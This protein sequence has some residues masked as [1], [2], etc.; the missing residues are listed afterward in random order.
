ML[1]ADPLY[2]SNIRV[3][4]DEQFFEPPPET[5]APTVVPIVV[6]PVQLNGV[7]IEFSGSSDAIYSATDLFLV[8]DKHADIDATTLGLFGSSDFSIEFTFS[9]PGGDITPD[10][11][12]GILLTC[13]AG[14]GCLVETVKSLRLQALL[15]SYMTPVPSSSG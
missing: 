11:D 8:D 6:T 14:D 15:L 13:F 3:F 7:P 4:S 12:R 9:S 10:G 5:F 1:G 2:I